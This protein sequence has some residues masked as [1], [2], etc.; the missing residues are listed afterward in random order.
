MDSYVTLS[1]CGLRMQ[2]ANLPARLMARKLE[3]ATEPTL[4]H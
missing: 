3:Q 4:A 1:V 2:P